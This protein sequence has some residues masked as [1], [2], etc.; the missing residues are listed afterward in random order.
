MA[1]GFEMRVLDGVN[2]R[3]LAS[4]WVGILSMGPMHWIR[5]WGLAY[6]MKGPTSPRIVT[7]KQ[8]SKHAW[9]AAHCTVNTFIHKH[10]KHLIV[11]S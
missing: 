8:H 2:A 7:S 6:G 4:F 10:P 11:P 1:R 3:S 5:E 9:N